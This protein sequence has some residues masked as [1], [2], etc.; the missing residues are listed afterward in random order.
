MVDEAFEKLVSEAID[1]LPQ[2]FLDKL[3]NVAILVEDQPSPAQ[4]KQLHLKPWTNLLGLYEGVSLLGRASS[5]ASIIP[6]KI[7]I[8]KLPILSIS[9]DPE[10]IKKSVRS[11][12][13]H[14]VAHHFGFSEERIRKVERRGSRN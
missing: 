1:S 12:V 11:V 3:E 8:F 10:E 5:Y 9:H 13:L 7:T 2:E 6:D 4:V 14:E